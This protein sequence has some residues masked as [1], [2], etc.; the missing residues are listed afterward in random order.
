MENILREKIKSFAFSLGDNQRAKRG[1]CVNDMVMS[2]GLLRSS[3][4]HITCRKQ[5]G[6]GFLTTP[7]EL[8]GLTRL[9][10]LRES[11][12]LPREG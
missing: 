8:I 5:A 12:K 1:K 4:T 7:V 2:W 3:I 6:T 11:R 10:Y 9:Q